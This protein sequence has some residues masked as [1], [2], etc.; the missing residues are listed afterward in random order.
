V[1][2]KWIIVVEAA[3]ALNNSQTVLIIESKGE[4]TQSGL[5]QSHFTN[6]SH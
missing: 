2:L 6:P 5:A 3:Y 4:T 1:L